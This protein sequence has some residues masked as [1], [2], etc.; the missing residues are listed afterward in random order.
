MLIPEPRDLVLE[1]RVLGRESGVVPLR[2]GVKQLGPTVGQALDF[3]AN[4]GDGHL[5]V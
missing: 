5:T 4:F 3:L 1:A 2:K